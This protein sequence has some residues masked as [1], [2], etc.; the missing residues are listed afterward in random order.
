[1]ESDGRSVAKTR[2]MVDTGRTSQEPQETRNWKGDG[3]SQPPVIF[4]YGKLTAWAAEAWVAGLQAGQSGLL[5][6]EEQL[7]FLTAVIHTCLQEADEEEKDPDLRSE[8][9]RCFLHGVPGAG[10]SLTWKWVR[11]FFEDVCDWVHEKEFVLLAPQNTQAAWIDGITVDSFANLGIKG[12]GRAA[13]SKFGP[14]KLLQN[15]QEHK[16]DLARMEFR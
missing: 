10:K 5:S 6:S 8:S 11:A 2:A 12:D 1:M 13:R 9:E 14:D 15:L 3:E 16:G 7:A 4:S